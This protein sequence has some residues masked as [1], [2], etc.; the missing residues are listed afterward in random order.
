[1]KIFI[2]AFGTD[3]R[4]KQEASL[5]PA[6]P[7]LRDVLRALKDQDQVPLE[8]FI[9]DDLSLKEGCVILVNGRNIASLDRLET[10]V[11]DGDELTFTVLVAGGGREAPNTK[12]QITNKLQ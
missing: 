10:R 11:Q 2:N 3:I 5:E 4:L 8:R 12:R 7:A 9:E 6:S 1:M